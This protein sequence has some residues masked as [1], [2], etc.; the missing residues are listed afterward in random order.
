MELTD[1]TPSSI[2]LRQEEILHS[3]SEH[4]PR[5]DAFNA[6][7]FLEDTL[8]DIKPFAYVNVPPVHSTGAA[9]IL[10]DQNLQIADM[11]QFA[12]YTALVLGSEQYRL[13]IRGRTGLKQGGFRKMTVD[14]NEV[15]TLKGIEYAIPDVLD[16]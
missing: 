7:L 5:L 6:S 3:D 1:P 14:Y 10:I 15:V 13:G 9:R 12:R 11:R 16:R 2:H 4:H 8:P